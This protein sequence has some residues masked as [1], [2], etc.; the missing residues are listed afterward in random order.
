VEIRDENYEI[1]RIF[2][3]SD[4]VEILKFDSPT[5]VEPPESIIFVDGKVKHLWRYDSEPS[6]K[7]LI[8]Q[9]VVGAVEYCCKSLRLV[10]DPLIEFVA[11][12]SENFPR[13]TLK[14]WKNRASIYTIRD[15][16]LSEI[17]G[18]RMAE[19][20]MALS[21]EIASSQ[22]SI[23]VKDGSLKP[24]F[25]L[26]SETSFVPGKGPVGLVK[27]IQAVLNIADEEK[28]LGE[29]KIGERSRAFKIRR[30]VENE[31][32]FQISSYLKISD[33]AF[34]RMD[35]VVRTT[36]EIKD[37]LNLFNMLSTVIPEL[38]IS[39]D[40]GRYPSDIAPIQSLEYIL[41]G[42]MYHPGLV[43]YLKG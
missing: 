36:N 30:M 8:S 14:K 10:T 13:D 18:E 3:E 38:T 1:P 17:A 35:A 32:V 24:I 40:Y 29:L 34:L 23:V 37:A 4:E 25:V 42:Y 31:E 9:I 7:A 11:A 21:M 26:K 5:K 2:S 12:V 16:E 6:K 19:L 28:L 15:G 27:N 33:G 22:K 39:V 20:E 41:G 43:E